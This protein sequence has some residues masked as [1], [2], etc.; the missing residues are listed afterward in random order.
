VVRLLLK[1]NADTAIVTK[2]G[3][4][5]IRA[6]ALGGHSDVIQLLL[7]HGADMRIS[8]ILEGH[9]SSTLSELEILPE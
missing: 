4:T 2:M 9:H 5:P 8:D 1:T 3:Q 7:H 6:A